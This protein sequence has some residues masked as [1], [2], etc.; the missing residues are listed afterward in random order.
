MTTFGGGPSQVLY[1]DGSDGGTGGVFQTVT[2]V[3][4]ASFNGA[5]M[6]FRFE[7]DTVD[8]AYNNFEGIY[9]GRSRS[10]RARP[11]PPSSRSAAAG[12]QL[13]PADDGESPPIPEQPQR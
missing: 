9:I 1:Q 12:F 4:P 6:R 7:F 8:G 5:T 2:V 3:I 13:G 10:P 11:Q